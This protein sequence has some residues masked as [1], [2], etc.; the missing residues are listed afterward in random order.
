[1]LGE[2]APIKPIGARGQAADGHISLTPTPR[3]RGGTITTMLSP[4]AASEITRSICS[5]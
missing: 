1:V 2:E 4:Q 5:G 3:H